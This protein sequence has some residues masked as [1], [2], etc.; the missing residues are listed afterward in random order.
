LEGR[1]QL[2][3]S[4]R[5][6]YICS[7]FFVCLP[8]SFRWNRSVAAL[9]CGPGHHDSM[10]LSQRRTVGCYPNGRSYCRRSRICRA[11]VPRTFHATTD[12]FD[13]NGGRRRGLGDLFDTRQSWPRRYR[14]H[15]WQLPAY[16]AIRCCG[17]HYFAFAG[18]TGSGR[19]LLRRSFR[20][21]HFR[22]WLRYLVQC[23][24]WLESGECRHGAT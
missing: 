1:R 9:R 15:R 6:L 4:S 11:Y 18:A 21:D 3:L 12:W 19:D 8:R 5:A 23:I 22:T 7:G 2:V 14:Y 16:R 20:S 24:A 13:P 10:G 17:Q